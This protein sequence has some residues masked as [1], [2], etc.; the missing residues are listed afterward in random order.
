VTAAL[1]VFARTPVR[2][3]VKSRLAD[4]V[5]P[6][7]ALEIYRVLLAHTAAVAAAWPGPVEI[8]VAGEPAP[9]DPLAGFD[10]RQQAEGGLGA[11]LRAGLGPALATHGRAI[12]IGSDCYDCWTGDLLLVADAL[13]TDG[14]C[15][16]PST[17]GGYWALALAGRG[18]LAA[19]CADDLPWSTPHL[20]EETRRRCRAAAIARAEGPV[21]NDLD[22]VE[23][24]VRA[25]AGDH[26]QG[27]GSTP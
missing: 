18:A 19:C 13:P 4:S 16:A 21:R 2:G 11:R 3:T 23:D 1:C 8:H 27:L 9:E 17:D 14:A 7:H 6:D 10:R 5:G 12:A 20:V 22:T 15:I 25:L 24:L 26:L